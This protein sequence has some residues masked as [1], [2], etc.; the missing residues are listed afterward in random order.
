[1]YY[2]CYRMFDRTISKI[3]ALI[4]CFFLMSCKAKNETVAPDPPPSNEIGKAQVWLTKGDQSKLL[5]R[6]GDL[7]ISKTASSA[8]PVITIDT[9]THHQSIEGFGAALTG[10]AAYLFHKKLSAGARQTLLRQLFDTVMALAFPIC[11]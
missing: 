5:H 10:S 2:N 7:S 8:W 3:L 11:G 6:E 1:M 9:V 4:F